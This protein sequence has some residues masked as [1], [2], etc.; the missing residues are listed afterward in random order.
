MYHFQALFPSSLDQSLCPTEPSLG[1]D[2]WILVDQSCQLVVL[3][4]ALH[5][6]L[7][8]R[9]DQTR[10]DAQFLQED[11]AILNNCLE[12]ADCCPLQAGQAYP[13]VSASVPA[14]T[15]HMDDILLFFS[16]C[17]ILR[18][19]A[20]LLLHALYLGQK[21]LTFLDSITFPTHCEILEH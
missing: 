10:L 8:I 4:F 13:D 11:L 18:D 5:C 17:S 21:Q 19:G 7:K 2:I 3:L 6:F 12:M 14:G 9:E 16:S 15:K 1:R 20:W